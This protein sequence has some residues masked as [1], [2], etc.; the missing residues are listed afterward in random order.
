MQTIL[1]VIRNLVF[2]FHPTNLKIEMT[3]VSVQVS[4]IDHKKETIFLKF[5]LSILSLCWTEIIPLSTSIDKVIIYF[6]FKFIHSHKPH[7]DCTW[8]T[9][10]TIITKIKKK[11]DVRGGRELQNKNACLITFCKDRT[12]QLLPY[13]INQLRPCRFETINEIGNRKSGIVLVHVKRHC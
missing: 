1:Y 8:G 4:Y 5:F 2:K 13:N 10:H 6:K 11:S 7:K 9:K 3:F 12:I